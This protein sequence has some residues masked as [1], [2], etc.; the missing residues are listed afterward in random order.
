MG[1]GVKTVLLRLVT[2]GRGGSKL[3][4]NVLRNLW[5]TPQAIY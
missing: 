2:W 1:E 4:E 3:L 5:T